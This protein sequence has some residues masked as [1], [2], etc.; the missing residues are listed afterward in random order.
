MIYPSPYP[1]LDLPQTD[2]YSL[3]FDGL[4]DEEATLPAITELLS[5]IHI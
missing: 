2:I 4:T 5:L 1:S 3:I